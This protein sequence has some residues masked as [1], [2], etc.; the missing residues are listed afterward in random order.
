VSD[1]EITKQVQEALRS[2][3]YFNADRITVTTK[4]GVVKLEGVVEDPQD[5]FT[6]I[7]IS[8][9]MPGAKGVVDELEISDMWDFDID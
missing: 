9:G 8:N 4:D 6:A 7:R 1:E 2:S 5:L 3:P